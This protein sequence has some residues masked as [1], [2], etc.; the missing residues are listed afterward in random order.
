[1]IFILTFNV[2]FYFYNA[3]CHSLQCVHIFVLDILDIFF[4]CPRGFFT[5]PCDVLLGF[6]G[7]LT[8]TKCSGNFLCSFSRVAL[9]CFLSRFSMCSGLFFDSWVFAVFPPVLCL[10]FVFS[11]L[12]GRLSSHFRNLFVYDIFH[13][14]LSVGNKFVDDLDVVGASLVGPAPTIS[15]FLT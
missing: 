5:F 13:F 2:L 3:V 6:R 9:H 14:I 1:M 11:F 4:I 15:S 12:L 7:I 10:G 8:V